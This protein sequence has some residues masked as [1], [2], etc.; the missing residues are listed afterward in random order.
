MGMVS[1]LLLLHGIR[2]RP[3][4]QLL[5]LRLFSLLC[6]LPVGRFESAINPLLKEL[7]AEITLSDNAQA[8][9]KSSLCTKACASLEELFLDG[10]IGG[11]VEVA[12]LEEGLNP[13]QTA[14]IG[15][16]EFDPS[17]LVLKQNGHRE[18]V[19]NK[20]SVKV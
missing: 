2:I 9:Q 12:Y 1:E 10:W 13:S 5:H 20:W 17:H 6:Q 14:M 8:T 7:V 4:I 3:V 15:S 11:C 16:L 18:G 19:T